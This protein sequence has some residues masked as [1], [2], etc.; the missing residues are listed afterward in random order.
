M[1]ELD[2]VGVFKEGVRGNHVCEGDAGPG[3]DEDG[4]AVL[5]DGVLDLEVGDCCGNG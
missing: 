3:L 5:E 2:Q 4:F 1:R